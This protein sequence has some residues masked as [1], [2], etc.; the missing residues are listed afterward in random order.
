AALARV[1]RNLVDNAVRHAASR[2]QV[3]VADGCVGVDD[4]GAGVTAADRER[5]FERFVR[6]DD[7]RER[8][9]G[10]SG[11]GLAIAR[12]IAREHGGDVVLGTSPLGG[13]AATLR[14]PPPDGAEAA[15][16]A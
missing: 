13:L 2:V 8:E 15:R 7:A 12:E 11:L 4:D 10:G 9:S 5:V 1:V 14:L 6:L 3:H 16:R